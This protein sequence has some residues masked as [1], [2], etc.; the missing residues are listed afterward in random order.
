MAWSSNLN[1]VNCFGFSPNLLPYI[2]EAIDNEKVKWI[3]NESSVFASSGIG[4]FKF[5]GC[6]WRLQE[7]FE[8][9]YSVSLQEGKPNQDLTAAALRGYNN[10]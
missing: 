2:K 1:T 3:D 8:L 9:V 7:S 10:D 6:K 5:G 4:I